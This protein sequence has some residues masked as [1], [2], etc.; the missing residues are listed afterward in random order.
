M[1]D[2]GRQRWLAERIAALR[3]D[4]REFA[5]AI[6]SATVA[7]GM[8]R[9]AESLA[10]TIAAAMTG[11]TDRPALAQRAREVVTD[12]ATG[13]ATL[14]L[15]PRYDAITYGEL[16]AR[17]GALAG[18]WTTGVSG[19]FEAGDFVAVLGFTGIDYATI[20]LTCMVLG[21][22]SVPLP[23]SASAAHLAPVVDE[24]RPRI[25]A[26]DVESVGIAVDVVLRSDSIERLVVF[27]YDGRVDDQRETLTAVVDRLRGRA[28]VVTLSD[29]LERAQGRLATGLPIN[30]DPERLAGLIYTSGSTGTPKGAMYTEGMLT[31]MW[32]RSR[33]GMT[34]AGASGDAP[35]PT[36]VLHYMP[37]SHA[38]GRSWL[39][40]GLAS[41]GI[42][43]FVGR[44]DLSTLFEDISLARPTVLSLV[45]RICDMVF[46]LYQIEL[47]QYA[48]QGKEDDSNRAA[49]RAEIRDRLLGG[50]IL[51]ALCGSAPLS[52][53]MR[54]FTESVLGILVTDCYGSTETGR[55]VVVNQQVRRPPVVD[56]KL[57]DVPE[58]GYF[59]TDRPHPR[60]ELRLK[61]DGMVRGYYRQ[62]EVTAR[63][64]DEE[65]YYRTGDIMA[66]VAPDRLVYVDRI[67]SVVKL[68]QGEF[69]EISRLEALYS[70]S[71]CIEQIYLY[72]SSE[73][74]F[75][76][77][78]VVPDF[79]R[80]GSSDTGE[81]RAAVSES[82]RRL[83]AEAEVKPYEI[84]NDFLLEPDRFSVANGLLSGVGKHLRP[85]LKA[86]YGE[87]LESRYKEI[88]D[89]R[90]GLFA[91][92]RATGDSRPTLDTV[93]DTAQVAL[94]L[95]SPECQPDQSFTD[96]GGDSLSAHTFS[97]MLGQVFG[98]DIPIQAIIGPEATL[99]GVAAYVDTVRGS[100]VSRP[101]FASVHGSGS[102]QVS[103]ADLT[104]DAFIDAGTLDRATTLPR[105]ADSTR[106]V[107]LTGAN[108]FLGRFLCLEWLERFAPTG[109]K[110]ICLA[111]GR[112]NAAARQRIDDAFKGGS[113]ELA[114]RYRT[115][116]DRHLE[117]LAGDVSAPRLGL[118][119]ADWD[120]LAGTVDQIVHSAALVNHVLPYAQLFEPN[121]VGT[122]ELTRLALT[123][124]RKRFSYISTVGVAM[125]PD[126]SFIGEDVDIRAA[127]AV[128][129]LDDTYANGYATSKW[130]GEVLLRQAH[131][132]CGLPVGVFRSDMILA[133]SRFAGQLNVPD[134]FTR[135]LLSVVATGV[136]PRSFYPMDADGERRRAHY[137]GL[138][139][140]FT[141]AAVTS[142][143]E[144]VREGYSTYNAVNNHDDGI[145]L[146]QFVDWLIELGCR[147]NRID[148]YQD[149]RSR[150]EIALKTLPERQRKHS[151]LPLIHAYDTPARPLSGALVPAE[152][153]HATV[154]EC[155]VGGDQGVPHLS[156]QLIE[157]Y[158]T[159]LKLLA[160]L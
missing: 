153:F 103:A 159:D 8:R 113:A 135:L 79:A 48:G 107:L 63:A 137:S 64:F 14:E 56:Y 80:I 91:Q 74:A 101:S 89:R 71:P 129:P 7:D 76:L 154:R 33:G 116:A 51:S 45:P 84:P 110:L 102:S 34:N 49:A 124:R 140:D 57:V 104:L 115:L 83:A 139:V 100:E 156:M 5:A 131:D 108:G 99:T 38:N 160:L 26:A 117:V 90:T 3:V 128:R 119:D 77:A 149:W 78:V 46:Q 118:R 106:T 65:G 145:S 27:D 31:Q 6:P 111:R 12:P 11:Y 61:S 114:E 146:D 148:D 4:D 42:G 127:S 98:I 130:A 24:T 152:R 53:Q 35:L 60:G 147:I 132:H 30:S 13:R 22:V 133:H 70:S 157:K 68:S 25:L 150:F 39:V 94:G 151:L 85:E 81:V 123:T 1:T 55:P 87:I 40:S 20:D 2:S 121:V 136:A 82:I 54:E 92:V 122:A 29:E 112:D 52:R 62:P 10:G 41:G 158:V 105:A 16:W 141:A 28:T 15:L 125:L 120:R 18:A 67:N 32:Q 142:L 36:I 19:G 143:G 69:V 144:K 66:E 138:P 134:R 43:F 86:R 88:A 23:R 73:Q 96:L 109:G 126:G 50:R 17:V 44:S 9:A 21:A 72:G 37:M 95:R 155:G 97:T 59:Q 75:L 93:T 58:L 47:E